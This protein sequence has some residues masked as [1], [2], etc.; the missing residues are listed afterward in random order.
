MVNVKERLGEGFEGSTGSREWLEPE[1][2]EEERASAS[3]EISDMVACGA[4]GKVS[5]GHSP[6]AGQLVQKVPGRHEL[7][8]LPLWCGPCRICEVVE[9]FVVDVAELRT[10]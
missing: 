8:L 10:E 2:P 6:S 3:C 4:A 9:V 1:V 7:L 5:S